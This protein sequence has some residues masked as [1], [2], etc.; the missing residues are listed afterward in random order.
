M[1]QGDFWQKWQ[2]HKVL[3][4]N[5]S[6]HSGRDWFSRLCEEVIQCRSFFVIFR[7]A[8]N[9]PVGSID[10][11]HLELHR[12]YGRVKRCAIL[13]KHGQQRPQSI[14]NSMHSLRKTCRH[15]IGPREKL[16]TVFFFFCNF[17]KLFLEIWNLFVY[18]CFHFCISWNV[19]ASWWSLWQSD[20]I[21]RIG[22]TSDENEENIGTML[23]LQIYVFR[24]WSWKPF[25]QQSQHILWWFVSWVTYCHRVTSVK[26]T[27]WCVKSP[28]KVVFREIWALPNDKDRMIWKETQDPINGPLQSCSTV[29]I[30]SEKGFW[31]FRRNKH[32]PWHQQ[33]IFHPIRIV[34]VLVFQHFHLNGAAQTCFA[35]LQGVVSTCDCSHFRREKIW[36]CAEHVYNHWSAHF[37][38]DCIRLTVSRFTHFTDT[39]AVLKST[40]SRSLVFEISIRK[41]VGAFV[42]FVFWP[43]RDSWKLVIRTT[44]VFNADIEG[45]VPIDEEAIDRYRANTMPALYLSMD[46]FEIQGVEIWHAR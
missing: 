10:R 12:Y 44:H 27:L 23:R 18:S 40:P 1:E 26:K 2:R 38:H 24:R 16:P 42:M 6:R 19:A 15:F 41:C 20:M 34:T 13:S 28:H 43:F 45:E 22:L 17:S 14:S 32:I 30:Q 29:V 46:R 9:A 7:V 33:T 8:G 4:R 39:Y 3:A 31:T 35:K 37:A 11:I 36:F 21:S 5:D 25:S